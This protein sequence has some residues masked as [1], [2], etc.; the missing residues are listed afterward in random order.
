LLSVVPGRLRGGVD[1]VL[2]AG[3]GVA[4]AAW[5]GPGVLLVDV[6]GHGRQELQG[7][8][9]SRTVGWFTSMHPVGVDVGGVDLDEVW[10]GGPAAGVVLRRVKEQLR[11]AP[12]GGLGYGLLRY[13][14]EQTRPA[15]ARLPVPQVSFNYLGRFTTGTD[16]PWNT[17]AGERAA[18]T[19][20]PSIVAHHLDINAWIVDNSDSVTLEAIWFWPERVF[21]E[22][23]V[24]ELAD[25]WVR[26]VGVLVDHVV[27]ADRVGLS[28]S[29]LLVSLSQE[30]IDRLEADW[31]RGL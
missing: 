25:L 17:P 28:P 9:L 20:Q 14:N 10:A 31:G 16:R 1:E 26:A 30:E 5:V 11:A 18:Q 22:G 13:L 21:G 2:L 29:D 15:L 7:V 3:L 24:E 4:V 19:P 27:A 12:D 23:V 6:E 8:D